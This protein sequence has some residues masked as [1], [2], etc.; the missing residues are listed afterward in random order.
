MRS[1]KR[2]AYGVKF[3]L[4]SRFLSLFSAFDY[5]RTNDNIH[6]NPTICG[7]FQCYKQPKAAIGTLVSFRKFYPTSKVH[8]FCDNGLDFSHVAKHFN[9]EYEYITNPSGKGE[10]LFF[11]TK[12]AVMN[13][14]QRLLKTAQNST[15]DFVMILEDDLTLLGSVD[16][17]KFDY[18]CIKSDHHFSG[19]KLTS[20][21]RKRNKSIPWY[22]P[23]MY[24]TGCGGASV[25]REFIVKHFSDRERLKVA[26]DE[27]GDLMKEQWN[28]AMP[29]DA[30][31]T[32]LILYFGGTTG[33][34]PGFTEPHKL[35]YKLRPFLGKISIVHHDKS[36]YN[37]P[38]SDEESKI[39]LGQF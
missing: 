3:R 11:L 9:C 29:Q 17:F 10:T 18:N 20:F 1:L 38:M 23:N 7:F 21:L 16:K 34:Y 13:Y 19:R 32:A 14:M 35:P 24:F 12:E 28:G 15:E 26:I 39:F 2:I 6:R 31:L 36:L 4:D 5:L 8:M 27:T 37:V 30:I 25:N 22:I 33:W